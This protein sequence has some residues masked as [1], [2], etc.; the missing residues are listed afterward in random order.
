MVNIYDYTALYSSVTV[1]GLSAI[2]SVYAFIYA[3]KHSNFKWVQFMLFLCIVQN[4]NTVILAIAVFLE[5]TP[6]HQAHR[7]ELMYIIG[8]SIFFFYFVS[9]LMYW[10]FGF[11]YWVI[12]IEIPTLI[13]Y[14]EV[15]LSS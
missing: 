10:L 9:N 12:S 4:A 2:Y 5:V 15:E 3:L 8:F 1:C 13:A 11:K 14:Q 6:W 7:M